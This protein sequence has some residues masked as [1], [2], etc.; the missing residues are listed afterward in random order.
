MTAMLRITV[1]GLMLTLSALT[2]AAPQQRPPFTSGTNLVVVP[3]VVVDRKGQSVPNL[4][5]ADF[6]V[7]EDGKRMPVELFT[8]ASGAT[9]SSG[10]GRFIVVVLDNL[11]TPAELA[12]RVKGIAMRFVDRMGPRDTMTVIS[13]S[14]G[15]ALTTTDKAL[16]NAAVDRFR[17]EF[18]DTTRTA[19][20]DA[21][22]S[23]RTIGELAAQMSKAPQRRKVMA[24]IGNTATF[25]PQRQSAFAD[26][27]P[28]LS[29]EWFDAIRET[30]RYN[31]SV[32]AIDA[33]GLRDGAYPADFATSFAAET[34]GWAWANTNNFG[35]AVEQVWREAGSYYVLGYHA[36][37]N[38]SKLHKVD[39]KTNVKGVTVRARRGRY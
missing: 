19:E 15:Q 22:H 11:R 18:G 36:P 34:G 37:I 1:A 10:E 16:L 32:Y 24:I 6:V 33:L 21:E 23:L 14:K 2:A 9:E 29:Q 8:A 26:R 20:Q 5:A 25:N 12:F 39:V 4:T 28:D 27:G 35:A 13:L 31:V 7:E 17:P 30:A 38:D 3:V